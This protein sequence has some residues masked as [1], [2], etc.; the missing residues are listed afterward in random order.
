MSEKQNGA[1]SHVGEE[2]QA[3]KHGINTTSQDMTPPT[4][5]PALEEDEG[6]QVGSNYI[7]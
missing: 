7:A 2:T 3:P 5:S 1:S 4:A 6:I